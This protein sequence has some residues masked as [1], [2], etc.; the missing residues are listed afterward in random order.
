[1]TIKRLP[2]IIE[3]NRRGFWGRTVVNDN[4]IVDSATSVE[5]LKKKLR[6]AINEIENIEVENFDISFDLT[7]FFEQYTFLNISDL[8]LR[9]QISP[10]MLRQYK[11]GIKFPSEKRVREIETA[12]RDIGKELAK[13]KLHKGRKAAA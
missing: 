3:M 13:V 2:M 1:M 5:A 12:I 9:I 8:A 6:K 7:S 4:L 11:S 10:L